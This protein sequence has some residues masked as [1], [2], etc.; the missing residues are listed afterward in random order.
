M[1]RKKILL[2]ED[3]E[4]DREIFFE[5]LRSRSDIVLLPVAADGVMLMDQLKAITDPSALPDFI[6]LD[7][8][9]PRQNG[10]Q[11]LHLIKADPCYAH[12]PVVIYSTY[13]DE[14]LMKKGTEAGARL[15]APKPFSREGYDKMVNLFLKAHD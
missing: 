5:F 4:D 6:I 1:T 14:V 13:V 12:I 9:M 11:T 15:V 7:Q 3:D 2:A 10:I 8:N